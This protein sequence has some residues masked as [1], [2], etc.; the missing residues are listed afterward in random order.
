[1]T[2][3][4]ILFQGK[5]ECPRCNDGGGGLIYQVLLSKIKKNVYICDEC[6][7]LWEDPGQIIQGFITDFPTYI[8]HHGYVYSTIGMQNANYYWYKSDETE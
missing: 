5:V 2:Q 4:L 1:M 7:S 3:I 6:E 8:E